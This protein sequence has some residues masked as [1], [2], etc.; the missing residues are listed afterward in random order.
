MVYETIQ[1]LYHH[2]AHAP[3]TG[4]ILTFFKNYNFIV[5]LRFL[6]NFVK[7]KTFPWII[8]MK[9]IMITLKIDSNFVFS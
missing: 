9:R 5:F 2:Q 6:K 3:W 1:K 8:N 7:L 4:D